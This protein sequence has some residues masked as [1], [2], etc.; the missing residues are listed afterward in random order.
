M[1]IMKFT[2]T[3]AS[4]VVMCA[5]LTSC[6]TELSDTVPMPVP[7]ASESASA[8]PTSAPSPDP[9]LL[10]GGTA[11]A[12]FDYFDFVNK[13]LLGVNANPSSAA[14]VENL[15]N[16]GFEK[17]DLEVTPDKTDQ[18]RRPVDSIQFSVRT[19]EGCLLGQF[20]AGAYTSAVGAP[21]NGA[22]CLIG[23]TDTI[24]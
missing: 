10:P 19:S 23:E 13:R 18:L 5:V 1:R 22:A 11:L 4:A 7:T 6:S 17:S 14:I 16:A 21:V 12:N 3:A 20:Q 15:V 2:V 9:T 8:A 24:P